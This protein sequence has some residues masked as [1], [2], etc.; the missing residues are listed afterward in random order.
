MK[1]VKEMLHNKHNTNNTKQNTNKLTKKYFETCNRIHAN[2]QTLINL[3]IGNRLYIK[4]QKKLKKYNER[5]QI[6]YI[7]LLRQYGIRL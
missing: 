4:L 3:S 5:R 1:G 2:R 7:K 6:L